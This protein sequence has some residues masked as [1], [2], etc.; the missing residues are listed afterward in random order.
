M[1][2]RFKR[3]AMKKYFLQVKK[4]TFFISNPDFWF[5]AEVAKD[6]QNFS[7]KVTNGF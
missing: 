4:Y 5:R 3:G 2:F 1:H 6:F 7:L